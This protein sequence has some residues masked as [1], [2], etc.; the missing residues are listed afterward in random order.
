MDELI[1]LSKI[2][3]SA[4]SKQNPLFDFTI[5]IGDERAGLEHRLYNKIVT[6]QF[7]SDGDAARDFY[8]TAQPDH[9]YR[10]LKSRLKQKL[11]NH[12][13][14]LD[15]RSPFATLASQYESDCINLLGQGKRLLSFGEMQL[16]E[17][18]V[19]KALKMATEAEFT[20]LAIFCYKMLRSIYSQELKS[21]ALDRVL[22]ELEHFRQI[23]IWKRSPTICLSP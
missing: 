12:L 14:F 4:G 3:D 20:E 5:D 6:G 15:L 23:E 9:R 11:L 7:L 19:N 2:I 8:G 1:R 16:T 22:E 13:F 18:L 21:S 10:M 17:K